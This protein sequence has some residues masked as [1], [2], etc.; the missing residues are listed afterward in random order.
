MN[1]L[2]LLILFSS[3][4]ILLGGYNVFTGLKR[5]GEARTRGMP[6]TWYKQLNLLTGIE[7][8]FLALV[9]LANTAVRTNT[10]PQSLNSILVPTYYV[11]LL[12]AAILAGIVIRQGFINAR[13]MR[14]QS[15]SSAPTVMSNG[16]SAI[17]KQGEDIQDTQKRGAN[18]E[19]RR[20]RR[21]NAASA[22][23]RR[24]GK[25]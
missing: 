6:L 15:R 8:I 1:T 4:F 16:T 19:R 9:F 13:T 5:I 2:T 21:R 25:A 14:G 20:E 24:A 10:L 17:T 7:Y 12:A 23:R 11:L 22:R 18:Q 3:I